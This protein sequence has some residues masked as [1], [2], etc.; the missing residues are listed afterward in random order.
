MEEEIMQEE[1]KRKRFKSHTAPYL[2]AIPYILRYQLVTKSLL[3]LLIIG[4]RIL[5]MLVLGAMG[6]SAVTSGDYSFLFSSW[7]GYLLL[8]IGLAALF[9]Y[10]AFD[11]NSTIVYSAYLLKGETGNI[12][13]SMWQ[14]FKSIYRFFTPHG[15]GVVLYIL[16][17]VPLVSVELSISLTSGLNMPN[18]I[19]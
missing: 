10:V 18:F 16:L 13:N 11:L 4:L 8:V 19:V 14:G 9:L 2:Q 5:S 12:L 1:T 7:Y 15:I 6:K 17:L 3:I